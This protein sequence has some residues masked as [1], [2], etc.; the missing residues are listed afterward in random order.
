MAEYVKGID[1][2]RWQGG[3]DWKAV[4]EDGVRFAFI[5]AGG[6]DAGLYIDPYFAENMR[7][8]HSQ[9]IRLGAYYY[10]G[11]NC[12]TYEDGH[13][14]GARMVHICEAFRDYITLPLIIDFEAPPASDRAG[15]SAAVRGFCAAVTASGFEAG[16]YASEFSGFQER[17]NLA[18][19][20][21]IFKWCAKWSAASP[22]TVDWSVW[23]QTSEGSVNGI[24]TPVD[25]DF[26][27]PE[28]WDARFKSKDSKNEKLKAAL[29]ELKRS[30]ENVEALL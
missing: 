5:K 14:D 10:V 30:M 7:A 20:P 1:V 12:V 23:Q 18:A 26:F 9:G 21:D 22:N 25:V 19:L 8:A 29:A 11:P 28:S 24:G 4:K 2:S 13:A 17:L 27:K 16:V 6:S 3:I 15:N